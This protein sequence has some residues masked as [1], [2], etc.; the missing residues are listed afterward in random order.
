MASVDIV[1]PCYNYGRYLRDCV[2][3]ALTQPGVDVRILIIDDQSSDNTFDVASE[4][5][6]ADS[7]VGFRRHQANK[8]HIATYNEGLS[9]ATADYVV[10]LSADDMLT[11][12]SLRRAAE[13]MDANPSVGLVYGY[14]IPLYSDTPPPPRTRATGC[15]IWKGNDWARLMCQAGRNFIN[16]PEVVMRTRIQ[17]EIGGYRPSLPHSGDMEMWLRA[18]TVSD[19][20]RINGADQAYYRIHNLSM[21]RTTY[22]GD[23]R[24]LQ[25]RL[26]AFESALGDAADHGLLELARRSLAIDAIKCARRA[27]DPR[28]RDIEPIDQYREFAVSLFPGIVETRD[29][30]ALDRSQ[31][32]GWN[33]L[34][35]LSRRGTARLDRFQQ[36]WAWRRWWRTGVY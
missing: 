33:F 2:S 1:I 25:G 35:T 27:A 32:A 16:C 10:L 23:M 14:P 8:G 3:S 20:A 13:I 21:Q 9:E 29:W 22:A 31:R 30:S 5:S 28:R 15:T 17:H 11:L 7:R 26:D 4:L 12:G 6:A 19:I 24:D 34:S 36:Y 18:A